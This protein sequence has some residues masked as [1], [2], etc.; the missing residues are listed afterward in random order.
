MT[1][2][3]RAYDCVCM[4]AHQCVHAYDSLMCAHDCGL[5]VRARYD[6]VCA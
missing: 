5:C 4:R 1:V 6:L 3:V 2:G